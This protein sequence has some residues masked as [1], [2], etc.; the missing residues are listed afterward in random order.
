MLPL[1][2]L[3]SGSAA[4]QSASTRAS[5]AVDVALVNLDVWV[6][7]PLGNPVTDLEANDFRL[8]VD[9]DPVEVTHFAVIAP[10]RREDE[11]E[12]ASS[13]ARGS[14]LRLAI[15]IDTAFLRSGELAA[16]EPHLASLLSRGLPASTPVM[17]AVADPQFEIVEGFTTQRQT[18]LDGIHRLATAVG[19]S[20]IDTEYSQIQREFEE[21]LGRASSGALPYVPGAQAESVLTQIGGLAASVQNEVERAAARLSFLVRSLQ[22]LPG[23]REVLFLT[24]R[25]PAHAGLDLLTAWRQEMG[26][27]ALFSQSPD[28]GPG[29]GQA[30][31]D[32]ASAGLPDGSAF[33]SRAT[34]IT[35]LDA[36]AILIEA[37]TRAAAG[38]VAIHAIDLSVS[39][40][41]RSLVRT[42]TAGQGAAGS[43]ASGFTRSASIHQ[44]IKDHRL[45]EDVVSLTGGALL[46][47]SDLATDGSSILARRHPHY[48]LA[49]TPPLGSDQDQHALAVRLT[50]QNLDHAL[51]YRRFFGNRTRDQQAAEATASSMLTGVA[52]NPLGASLDVGILAADDPSTKVAEVTLI[53]P[54]SRIALQPDGNDHIGQLSVFHLWGEVHRQSSAVRK[55]IL[56]LRIANDQMLTALGRSVEYSWE[57]EMPRGTPFIAVGIRDDL[58]DSLSTVVAPVE[59][60]P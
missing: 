13:A 21:V 47:G 8:M 24:G 55:G 18:V 38:G 30:S 22:G 17:L 15:Y 7:D 14:D 58:S 48:S 60:L 51:T 3:A 11:S 9:G 45:L 32:T 42:A 50:D 23:T 39:R 36:A 27:N 49:F 35:D 40:Q 19:R 5:E 2:A 56:P 20:R 29:G 53:L 25:P 1:V 33:G 59:D 43:P 46:S 57:M 52:Q 34:S 26:Q 4:A 12:T 41:S 16:I 37:A 44:G 31:E 28:T 54:F 10:L 6:T